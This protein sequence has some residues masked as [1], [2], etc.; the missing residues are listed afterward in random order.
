[1]CKEY[2]ETFLILGNLFSDLYIAL[3]VDHSTYLINIKRNVT[4]LKHKYLS[5]SLSTTLKSHAAF[6]H[7]ILKMQIH[8]C[9][10]PCVEDFIE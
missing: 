3:P 6:L 7:L 8:G 9:L 10:E 1:M 5:L 4:T 2:R